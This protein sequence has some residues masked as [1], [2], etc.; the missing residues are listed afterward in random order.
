MVSRSDPGL[1]A[2]VMDDRPLPRRRY[3]V[4]LSSPGAEIR[5][6]S[7]PVVRNRWRLISGVLTAALLT[8]LVISLNLP[9][10]QV[11]EVGVRGAQRFSKQ[12]IVRAVNAQGLPV[13]FVHP[14]RI[15]QDLQLTYPGLTDVQVEVAWPAR[16]EIAVQ[17]RQPVMAWNF[18][19]HVRWVDSRGVA[20][21]PHGL[22]E[23]IIMVHS[24]VLPPTREHRFVQPGL[25]E[26]VSILSGHLPEGVELEYS[27]EHGL[28]WRDP[29]GWSVY[30][31]DQAQRMRDKVLIYES[32][33]KTLKE[34]GI[35]P[36][37]ISVEY[38]DAPYFRME[39]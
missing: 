11:A 35:Q 27:R 23:E 22:G 34:K 8:A 15:E 18:E 21:E 31:G 26:A 20:F 19:G 9:Y 7:V 14:Q 37:F 38:A 3:D 12:E 6:P 5:L 28:G 32:I 30:F 17:E 4:A 10:F 13:F 33:Q 16:V 1:N 36:G 29:L 24:E 25:V 2:A 39:R